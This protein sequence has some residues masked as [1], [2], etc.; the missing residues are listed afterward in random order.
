MMGQSE[1]LSVRVVAFLYLL[2]F[3]LVYPCFYLF[4]ENPRRDDLLR[5]N[6]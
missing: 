3:I 5:E 4:H 1:N 2:L 6:D